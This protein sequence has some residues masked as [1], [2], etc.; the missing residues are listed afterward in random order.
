MGDGLDNTDAK[1][2]S[3]MDGLD[4]TDAKHN[5]EANEALDDRLTQLETL[6]QPEERFFFTSIP[7]DFPIDEF[8]EDAGYNGRFNENFEQNIEDIQSLIQEIRKMGVKNLKTKPT[9]EIVAKFYKL[10]IDLV[11]LI[12]SDDSVKYIARDGG[13]MKGQWGNLKGASVVDMIIMKKIFGDH[14][15]IEYLFGYKGPFGVKCSWQTSGNF[16]IKSLA[17]PKWTFGDWSE[18]IKLTGEDRHTM[19]QDHFKEKFQGLNFADAK[20]L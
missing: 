7:T 18:F 1:H 12:M 15:D 19:L 16:C 13:E 2:N 8:L 9:A 6:L 3:R 14:G 5:S 10:R 20:T 11:E 17:E 4:N